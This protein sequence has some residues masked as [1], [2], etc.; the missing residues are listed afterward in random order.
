MFFAK[1]FEKRLLT[2][3]ETKIYTASAATRL[4][5]TCGTFS[6]QSASAVITNDHRCIISWIFLTVHSFILKRYKQIQAAT[7]RLRAI[8]SF[9]FAWIKIYYFFITLKTNLIKM[10]KILKSKKSNV[11]LKVNH[12]LHV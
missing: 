3:K 8:Y 12:L 5:S 7:G 9:T 10:P 2:L 6:F 11:Q 1:K 4:R